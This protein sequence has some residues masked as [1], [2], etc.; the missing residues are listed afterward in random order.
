M[1]KSEAAVASSPIL[2]V[3]LFGEFFLE[4]LVP[5]T[6][7][8]EAEA[9][10]ERVAHQEWGGRGPAIALFK[11]LLCR[12]RRRAMKDELV[13]SLWPEGGEDEPDKR[14]K[15]A[16]RAL[17]AAASVLRRVLRAPD[18]ESLLTNVPARDG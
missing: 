5:G 12:H 13:E 3:F 1:N 14:L 11:L 10:Y 7:S 6:G 4:R 17:D 8:G 2:R 18:G 9:R 16:D 15:S